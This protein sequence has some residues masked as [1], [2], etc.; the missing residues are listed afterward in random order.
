MA[1]IVRPYDYTADRDSGSP[2]NVISADKLDLDLDTAYTAINNKLDKD[3]TVA[4][5]ADQPAGGFRITGHNTSAPT[6]RA[7]SISAA[8]LQDG[9]AAFVISGGTAD[10]ITATYSP[11]VTALVDGMELSFRA[12]SANATTTPTFAAN[13]TTAKTI[14]KGANAAL[15]ANDIAGQHHECRVRYNSTTDRWHL[16]NPTYIDG[17]K[18]SAD[19]LNSLTTDATGGAVADF[20]PFVDA[21]DSNASNKVTVQNFYDVSLAALTAKSAPIGADYLMIAD[22]AA[23]NAAKRSTLAQMTA[24]TTVTGFGYKG[25]P[26]NVQSGTYQFVLSDAGKT[27]Y[28][29]ST[30]HTY[31]IP[32][33]SGG[34]SPV[35]FDIG[36]TITIVNAAGSGTL[37]IAI[38]SDTLQRGDGVAG[39]GSRTMGPNSIAT[40]TKQTATVWY[41][42]GAFQ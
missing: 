34:G 19:S 38:T 33:N 32:A 40:L 11:V 2:N 18:L 36:T 3:G 14:V 5:T 27:I 8:N 22:S 37:T 31:T 12:A 10:A 35:A 9:S 13:A 17:V 6:A 4:W 41:I 23:S 42:T 28:H 7:H 15:V 26:Q 16:L 30:A 29:A 21:S 24:D 1:A 25:M 20:I 39:T